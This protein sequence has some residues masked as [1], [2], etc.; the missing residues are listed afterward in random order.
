MFSAD[1]CLVV[2]GLSQK[3]DDA[4]LAFFIGTRSGALTSFF[5]A[6]TFCGDQATVI[7]LCILLIALPSRAKT[8]LPVVLMTAAG[9]AV[10]TLIKNL[11]ARPR[12]PMDIWLIG[13]TDWLG[14]SFGSSFPSGHANTSMIFWMAL[15]ILAGRVL[16]GRDRRFAATLLRA[17]FFCFA[18]LI[19][20]S[21]LYLGVHYPSDVFGGWMLAGLL[22]IIFFTVI[23]KKNSLKPLAEIQI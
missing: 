20:V 12:P 19:G 21:R 13:E 7:P 8:G 9:T 4:I 6:L 17:G 10:Q 11:V 3:T 16:A 22:L 15:T 23:M 1:F 5:K 2:S 18:F 14:F